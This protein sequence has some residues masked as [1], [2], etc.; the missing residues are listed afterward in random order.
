MSYIAATGQNDNPVPQKTSGAGVN[1]PHWELRES[2]S[3][4]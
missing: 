4:L 1:L 2:Y 3:Y